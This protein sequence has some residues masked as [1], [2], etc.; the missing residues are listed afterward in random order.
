[1]PEIIST[2]GRF[3]RAARGILVVLVFLLFFS[4]FHPFTLSA[5]LSAQSGLD[6]DVLLKPATD[7]WPSYNGDYSGRRYSTLAQITT[8]NVSAL[9]LAW[10]A[11]LASGGGGLKGTPLQIGGVM[12]IST[13]D[14]A[15]ALDARTGRELW[16]FTWQSKGG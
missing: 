14:N 16:H 6:P 8:A 10:M 5:S 12:Y 11:P 2:T 9:S 3:I 15:Y 4:P 13:T 1:M 7:A